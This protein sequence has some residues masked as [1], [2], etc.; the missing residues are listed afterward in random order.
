MCKHRNKYALSLGNIKYNAYFYYM[1]T[2]NIE[3]CNSKHHGKGLCKTHYNKYISNPN[4]D[5]CSI[6][7]CT[8]LIG[9]SGA[10]GLC[11]NHYALLRKNGDPLILKTY[12][13]YASFE[14]IKIL[15]P[16]TYLDYE[17]RDRPHWG[18]VCKQHYGDKCSEC[19][20]CETSCDVDHIIAHK[21]G[22]KNTINNGRVL[23]PNCHAKKH[24]K[25][26]T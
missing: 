17:I 1:K 23:C 11:Q 26:R 16:D 15:Y 4:K 19:G 25:I 14:Q 22:G 12:R 9:K 8:N 6:P 21:Q 18:R 7:E 2:C 13:K 5:K 3:G 20:W 10:K 24:R